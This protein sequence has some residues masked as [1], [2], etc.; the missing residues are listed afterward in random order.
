MSSVD[1]AIVG[2]GA[3][4]IAAARRL[5][6]EGLRPLILEARDRVGGR[7][8]T[9]TSSFGL[10]LDRGCAWLHS[11]DQN[12]WAAL[13]REQGVTILERPPDWRRRVGARMRSPEERAA[14]EKAFERYFEL[15]SDAVRAGRDVAV[16][17]LVPDDEVRPQFDAIM[18]WYI[19]IESD[20]VS[21][22]DLA[23]FEDSEINWAVSEGLG[24]VVVRAAA[25]LDVRLQAPVQ[26]IDWRGQRLTL[27]TPTGA[28]EA[29]AVIVTV[30]TNVLAE[31]SIVFDPQ[32]PVTLQQALSDVPLGIANKVFFRMRPGALPFEGT[33]HFIGTDKTAHTCSYQVRPAGHEVLLAY[34][35]G[36]FARDLEERGE[37]ERFARDELAGI[38]GSDFER[39]I[40]ESVA[41]GWSQDPWARGSYS[42]ARPGHARAREALEQPVADRLF[43][44]GE[45]CSVEHFGT[46][47][48]AW[49]SAER[50]AAR[51]LRVIRPE[52]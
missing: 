18:T 45:A 13:A 22:I 25:D 33:T 28:V 10:P 3:A 12:P 42:A 21:S 1:I 40:V 7:A 39:Q 27:H 29:R 48:G 36:S 4:G 35:G 38:F 49:E 16:S 24:S 9:D 51:V 8:H 19:G 34:F 43:F 14:A 23:G 15:V 37:L 26:R 17:E 50:A 30:P 6:S 5:Q 44:A 11:A 20:S 41:V 32:L 46:I 31:G 47:H 52:R 2:A